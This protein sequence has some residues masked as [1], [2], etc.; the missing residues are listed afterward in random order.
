MAVLPE[1]A[2]LLAELCPELYHEWI[3][4]FGGLAESEFVM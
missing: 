2:L 1:R 3:L 4:V